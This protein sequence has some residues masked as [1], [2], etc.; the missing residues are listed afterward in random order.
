[1]S[2]R[3]LGIVA[4]AVALLGALGGAAPASASE[5]INSFT[6]TT[7]DTQA[8]GHPDVTVEANWDDRWRT[9][10][11]L[12]T[13]EP[14]TCNCNDAEGFD[15][16]FPTGFIGNPHN[17]PTC[18]LAEFSVGECPV[19]SQVGYSRVAGAFIPLYN[20]QP[21]PDEP[22]L[23]G[24]FVPFTSSAS[25]TVLHG[26]T[27]SDFGLDA[28]ATGIFHLLPI[29]GVKIVIWGVPALASHDAQRV[30][31]SDEL[32]LCF[33]ASS[34]SAPVAAN[35]P[36][37]QYL[38]N[39]TVCGTPLSGGLD[40]HYYDRNTVH[41]DTPWPATTGCGQ[42]SFN[43]SLTA[44]PT[45]TATDTPSGLDVELKVPQEQSVTVPSPSEIRTSIVTLPEGF[46]INAGAAD[47][48][49]A[50]SDE[51]ARI[52]SET[53][54]QCPEHAK[55]G[56]AVIDNV[57]LPGPIEGGIYLG[58]PRPGNRYRLVLTGDGFGSHVKL[59]G[60]LKADP[61]SGRLTTVFEDL[62]QTPTQRLVLHL[63]GSERGILATPERC[64]TYQVDSEFVPWDD[65]LPTQHSTSFFPVD[66]GP[67][68]SACPSA[69]RPFS[70][71]LQAGAADNTAATHSPFTIKVNRA[72]GDQNLSAITVATPPGLSATLKGIP[73]CPQAAIDQLAGP[74]HAGLGEI[75]APA[76]PTA[77]QVGSVIAAAGPGDHPLYV[78]GRAYLAGPYKGAPLSFLFVIP[79]VSGPYDLG[80][81]A[82]RAAL[83]VDQ[84]SAQVTAVS[85]PL[86]QIIGGIPLRTRMVQVNLD[87]PGF[88]L[89]PTDCDPFA[90]QATLSGTEGALATPANHFQVANCADLPFG[91]QLAI[92]LSG[93]TKRTGHTTLSA[94]LSTKGGE[95]NIA[96]TQISL[97]HSQFLDTANI[98]APC[99]RVQFAADACPAIS[100]VGTAK[101]TSPLL[102][103]PLE[104][105]V[106][107][108]S[109]SHKLPDLVADLRG[110][111]RIV[112]DG[113]I[114][115]VKG[116]TRTS[117]EEVPDVPVSSFTLT[118]PGGKKG[119][120]QNSE[121]LCAAPQKALISYGGQ[122]GKA[123]KRNLTLQ[124][125]CAK[126]AKEKRAKAKRA[127][128]RQ[129]RKGA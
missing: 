36:P 34:C 89:N 74:F 86:P 85:D 64:G 119:I 58:E 109:S 30:P 9:D 83:K 42:L 16:H 4:L 24:F 107:L 91:P 113:R 52:G 127:A 128:A 93:P 96:S 39:P 97:P 99:T 77:S 21:H 124:T 73:Y 26:R 47:G 8:G 118:L 18:T 111:L 57:A 20:M 23:L 116:R 102:G 59:L 51:Q 29:E 122:N 105:P 126:A 94:T 68:G 115:T 76:C 3:G 106:Y 19:E 88:T 13:P 44:T 41:A 5:A 45:T 129:K 31:K 11:E 65:Q 101:A 43:P 53:E 37:A 75:A 117:F 22:G 84:T 66:S 125:P 121:D 56:T 32:G 69:Q 14:G 50:C 95:A 12:A 28:S 63:F 61:Q 40:V 78:N 38:E 71:S 80:T 33:S 90:V 79:A 100:K 108:R 114:D 10:G 120:L 6:M 72:D 110:Q 48:K 46:A 104:G 92:K 49:E 25:F 112:L 60:S 17:V 7:S 15:V 35:T 70:P 103:Q 55:I 81:V 27:G 67:G 54:A 123:L 2:K 62:P 1:M 87:R 82:V 98:N